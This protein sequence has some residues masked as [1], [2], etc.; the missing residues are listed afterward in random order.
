MKING[1]MLN[2]EKEIK[3]IIENDPW[4]SKEVNNNWVLSHSLRT[5]EHFENMDFYLCGM[6]LDE[7]TISYR[8]YADALREFGVV[9]FVE[10]QVTG[11]NHTDETR[12][13]VQILIDQYGLRNVTNEFARQIRDKIGVE[14][15][16]RYIERRR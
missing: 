3:N 8:I 14:N 12:K 15:I 4:T 9:M 16:K 13:T 2:L 7:P 6:Y 10:D 11:I 1:T 5:P